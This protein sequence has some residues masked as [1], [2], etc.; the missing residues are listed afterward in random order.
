ML[1]SS[2]IQAQVAAAGAKS[3]VNSAAAA[4]PTDPSAVVPAA[5]PPQAL[6]RYK[7]AKLDPVIAD[8]PQANRTVKEAGGWRAYAKEASSASSSAPASPAAS[9][10]PASRHDHGAHGGKK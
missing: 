9:A 3:A 10:A 2:P 7:A 1:V 8:W 5:K 6:Q 4:D